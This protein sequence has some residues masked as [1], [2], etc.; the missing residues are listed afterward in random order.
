MALFSNKELEALQSENRSLKD[1]V[2]TFETRLSAKDKALSEYKTHVGE[3]EGKIERLKSEIEKN[4][5]ELSKSFSSHKVEKLREYYE[6]YIDELEEQLAAPQT[7]IHN[8]RGAGR[9]HKATP[10]QRE[11]I[12]SLF[13]QG[14]SQ[15]KIARMMTEQT[16]GKWNKTT[17]R[18]IIIAGKK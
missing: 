7:R 17:V 15:Y 10:K 13:S 4:K 12:I 14:V 2:A 3:L 11:Y 16:G 9:K 18:N 1:K 8:E 6:K 5:T